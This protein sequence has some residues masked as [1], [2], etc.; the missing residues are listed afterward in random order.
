MG[1]SAAVTEATWA[2][3]RARSTG[4]TQLRALLDGFAVPVA[5]GLPGADRATA[6]AQVASVTAV[7]L[8]A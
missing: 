2:A 4:P 6:T 3:A 8:G 1:R 7:L 5:I